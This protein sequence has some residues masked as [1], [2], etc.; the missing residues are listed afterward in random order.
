MQEKRS[1]VFLRNCVET[2]EKIIIIANMEKMSFHIFFLSF[3][4]RKPHSRTYHFVLLGYCSHNS[5]VYL[6]A[7]M[8]DAKNIYGFVCVLRKMTGQN[9]G[10]S[11][12]YQTIDRKN[13]SLWKYAACKKTVYFSNEYWTSSYFFDCFFFFCIRDSAI[14]VPTARWQWQ[15]QIC[16]SS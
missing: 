5:T 4:K 7:T 8:Y 14:H 12:Q 3:Q 16:I 6:L 11:F 13:V 2:D 9:F 1:N 10:N 15:P